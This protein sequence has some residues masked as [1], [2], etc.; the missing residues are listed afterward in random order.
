MSDLA[1]WHGVAFNHATESENRIHADDVAK[2]YGFRGGLVP[3]VTVYAYLVTPAVRVWGLDWL[4]SGTASVVLRKPL[5]D[6]AEFDVS[7][8]AEANDEYAVELVDAEGVLCAHGR[9]GPPGAAVGET[10]RRGDAP[11]GPVEQIPEATRPQLERLR[12]SGLGAVTF[13]WP[14]RTDFERYT[15]DL[16]AM[17]DCVRPDRGGYAHP[18]YT[19]GIANW[20]LSRNVRLGPWIHVQSD[21]RNHAPI[22]RGSRLVAEAR[23]TDLFARGGHEFVD[24]DV[25]VYIEPDQL[26]LFAQHRAIYRLA[27]PD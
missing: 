21:V 18:G 10:A 5:Y 7:V 14:G 16:E 3:G 22:P 4:T 19:L 9:I 11:A 1:N 25:A 15:R 6:G 24:L 8:G 23:V 20:A 12:E 26:A 27:A 2:Q 13:E 17:P